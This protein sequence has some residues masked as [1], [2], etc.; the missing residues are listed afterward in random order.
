[1]PVTADYIT[2]LAATTLFDESGTRWTQAE[3]FGY[4]NDAQRDIVVMK[5]TA[6]TKNQVVQ[7]QP[8]TLQVLPAD[9]QSLV[10]LGGAMGANG[11]TP[12][13]SITQVDRTVLEASRPT[14]R[15]DTATVAPRHY[16]YDDRDPTHFYVWPP[17]PTPAG[18]AEVVYCAVPGDIALVTDPIALGDQY[19][20]PLYYLVL[21]RAYSKT[22]GTQDFTKAQG[23]RELAMAMV[24]GRQAAKQR[25]HPEQLEERVKR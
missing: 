14:W 18:Y 8:G 24:Q 15:A 12:G 19:V 21:A 20:T 11:T 22:S 10:D 13:G 7:L 25:L 3:L 5:P 16:L 4:L 23:Y 17:Q 2:G 6:Y 9:G 1:M